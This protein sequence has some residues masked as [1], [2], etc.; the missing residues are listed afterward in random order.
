MTDRI[1]AGMHHW[2][3]TQIGSGYDGKAHYTHTSYEVD[4]AGEDS[5]V[6]FF[7]NYMPNTYFFCA[8]R[9]GTRSTG[10]TFFFWT[11]DKSGKAKKVLC[12][13]GKERVITL[14]LTHSNRNAIIGKVYGFME[15]VVTEGTQGYASGN[16]LHIEACEGCVMRK[17]QNAKGFYNLPNMLPLNKVFFICDKYTTVTN[18]GGLTWKHCKEVEVKGKTEM[19][20]FHTDKLP[21]R[22]RQKLSF[23]NGKPVGKIL[24]TMPKG[25]KA[26]ITHFTQRHELDGYEWFQV[27]Y[28]TESGAVIEGYVQGDLQAYKIVW[29][30]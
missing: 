12:A 6:D 7:R 30:R 4:V 17:I 18:S 29:V 23:Q 21:A 27:K 10:N 5:G 15:V 8:G 3:V 28:T 11:S 24:A 2:N 22:I 20:E 16:H 26:E 13:D 14:A 1:V 25:A 19:L 9:W